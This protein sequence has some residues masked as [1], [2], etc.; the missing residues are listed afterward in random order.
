MAILHAKEMT[1]DAL[2]FIHN[3]L[4]KIQRKED[5]SDFVIV[6]LCEHP[7]PAGHVR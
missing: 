7:G 5:C 1:E 4:G 3:S 6:P 2:R